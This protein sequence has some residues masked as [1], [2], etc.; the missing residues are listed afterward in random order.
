MILGGYQ[1]LSLCD[2]PQTPS[3]VLFSQGCNWRCSYCHN[4]ELIPRSPQSP[5]LDFT[6]VLKT[7]KRR[8]AL[9]RG[10]VF[11]G[12]EPTL[13]KDLPSCIASVKKLGLPVKLDSNGSQPAVLETLVRQGLVDYIAMDIKA[14][15]CK[16]E[17]ITGCPVD[18]DDIKESINL[19]AT[20][21]IAHQ[22][23]TTWPKELLCRADIDEIQTFLPKASDYVLQKC[24]QPEQ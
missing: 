5:T 16:Y 7:L 13:H 23:R 22:F 24:R 6:S 10:V 2:F 4:K 9:L 11:T 19:I 20:S 1:P 15:L 12:G 14:P 3:A 8:A 18:L 17:Q 21:G